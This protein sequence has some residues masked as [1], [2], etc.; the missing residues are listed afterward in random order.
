MTTWGLQ[1]TGLVSPTIDEIIGDISASY[2][3]SIDPALDL[4]ADQP[5]GQ[6]IAINADREMLLWNIIETVYAALDPDAAEAILLDNVCGITGT[7]RRSATY[8]FLY[9]VALSLASTTTVT[10]GATISVDTNPSSVWVLQSDITSTSAGDYPATFRSQS[11]GPQVG[12]MGTVKVIGTPTTGW[13]AVSN[14]HNAAQG[15]PQDTDTVLRQRRLKLLSAT[16]IGP[17]DGQRAALL[18]IP[19]IDDAFVFENTGNTTDVNGVP[20]HSTHAV[21]WSTTLSPPA[22]SST[23]ANTIAQ[24][25][26]SKKSGGNGTYGAITGVATDSAGKSHTLSFDWATTLQLHIVAIVTPAPGVTI[27]SSQ[28]E[29]IKSAMAGYALANFDLGVSVY[30]TPLRNSAVVAG[31]SIDAP[32]FE[33]KFGSTPGPTD[34]NSLA[35]TGLQIAIADTTNM[36]VNGI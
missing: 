13:T 29:A 19:D 2:L 32:T 31:V 28:A 1:D 6:S 11:P 16:S 33:I 25:I 9:E 20:P 18:E 7:R 5:I 26:W 34:I 4:S 27:G 17:I 36:T 12:N 14:P 24:A 23:L 22:S 10:A 35:V 8:S 21:L 30:Y 3:A 15:I